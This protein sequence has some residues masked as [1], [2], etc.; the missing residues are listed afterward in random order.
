MQFPHMLSELLSIRYP[1]GECSWS[2]LGTHGFSDDG[3]SCLVPKVFGLEGGLT[4]FG[5]RNALRQALPWRGVAF[6]VCVV[7]FFNKPMLKE[8][9]SVP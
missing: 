6:N 9:T 4:V 2:K 8:K 3:V 1:H 5:T 7:F